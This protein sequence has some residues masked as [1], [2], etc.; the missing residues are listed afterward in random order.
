MDQL[1]I[2]RREELPHGVLEGMFRL[3][4]KVFHEILGWDVEVHE[5]Q[6]RDRFDDLETYYA[7][8]HDPEQ[9]LALGCWRLLPTTEPYML[10]DVFPQIL[11]GEAAPCSPHVWEVS[12]FATTPSNWKA[13]RDQASFGAEAMRMVQAVL[14]LGH[15]RGIH[16]FVTAT[17]VQLESKASRALVLRRFGNGLPVDIGGVP[18]VAC[19]VDVESSRQWLAGSR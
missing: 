12:H 7:I 13:G 10:R 9:K 8:L 14:E 15:Q 17:S 19:W 18:S 4:Y 5:G 2:G 1:F 16:S 11:Q 3:R 6:E